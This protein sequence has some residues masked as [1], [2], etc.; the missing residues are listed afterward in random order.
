MNFDKDS[1]L[2]RIFSRVILLR[3]NGKEYT[4]KS[5]TA[6]LRYY[7]ELYKQKIIEEYK[8][9]LPRLDDY[10]IFL[11]KRGFIDGDYKIKIK[12]MND[13]I[14]RF[15]LELFRAGPL[16][17]TERRVRKNLDIMRKKLYEYITDIE[18]YHRPCLEYF[19]ENLKNKYI[20]MKTTYLDDNLVFN[21]KE[22][23]MPLMNSII[24]ELNE[25]DI[26]M[27]QFREMARTDP[28]R[29][30]WSANKQNLFG[31]SAI[32]FSEEQ[33]LLYNFSRMYDNVWEHPDVP[34]DKIVNSDDHLDGWFIFQQE[35]NKNKNKKEIT[36]LP[37]RFSEI[38]ITANSKEEADKI[39]ESNSLDG[40]RILKERA[41]VLRANKEVGQLA[42][43][44]EKLTLLEKISKQES[45]LM[46]SRR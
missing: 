25:Q 39:Y 3:I 34:D 36:N 45:Q 19:A 18:W 31:I 2:Y 17:E 38:Y 28:W 22:C 5:P 4:I 32:D 24:K 23:D 1:V 42:F 35:K 16:I 46:K 29:G 41:A 15:K 8:Y 20:L 33:R 44:D 7:A 26:S 13:A 40:I 6:L 30:Y 14:R 9:D 27:T 43:K 12:N 21:E 11:I 37:D 10:D